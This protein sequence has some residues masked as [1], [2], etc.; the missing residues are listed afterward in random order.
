MSRSMLTWQ[1]EM[2]L[3][4][5]S[6]LLWNC[7]AHEES[8]KSSWCL[9]GDVI[10]VSDKLPCW[11]HCSAVFWWGEEIFEFPSQKGVTHIHFSFSRIFPR[12]YLLQQ[13]HLYSL[14][15]LQQVSFFNWF[16]LLHIKPILIFSA[17]CTFPL[18]V[19]HSIN[20]FTSKPSIVYSLL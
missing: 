8:C 10:T 20:S 7:C 9:Q 13:I 15:D 11:H 16:Y 4:Q 12:E 5:N 14:A 19:N 3:A 1:L 6:F 18:L 2:T 17:N